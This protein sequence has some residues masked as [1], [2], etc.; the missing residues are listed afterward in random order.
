MPC[1]QLA[2]S[3]PF[4]GRRPLQQFG[5]FTLAAVLGFVHKF[6]EPFLA[7]VPLPSLRAEQAAF[8]AKRGRQSREGCNRLPVQPGSY[9]RSPLMTRGTARAP[10]L[11]A[12][13][14]PVDCNDCLPITDERAS[15]YPATAIPTGWL[16]KLD[17]GFDTIHRTSAE[18]PAAYECGRNAIT[19]SR[20]WWNHLAVPVPLAKGCFGSELRHIHFTPR[21]PLK[22]NDYERNHDERFGIVLTQSN[23]AVWG[24]TIPILRFPPNREYPPYLSAP[25]K[26]TMAFRLSSRMHSYAP[27]DNQR[28]VRTASANLCSN[29]SRRSVR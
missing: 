3:W 27:P 10:L 15:G 14:R 22:F 5:S 8:L 11:C 19:R 28:N 17:T 24:T 7:Y 16:A 26:R 21:N 2:P 4:F 29:N 13:N 20:R 9:C 6:W 18:W 1:E 12:T 25:H 23:Q